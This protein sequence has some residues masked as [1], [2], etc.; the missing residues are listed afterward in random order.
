LPFKLTIPTE[1]TTFQV[2]KCQSFLR[3]VYRRLEVYRRVQKILLVLLQNKILHVVC[4]LIW[5]T[6]SIIPIWN[7][8][9]VF[10]IVLK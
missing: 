2:L 1:V 6:K 9:C 5:N 8:S 7:S 10:L 4:T 3:L